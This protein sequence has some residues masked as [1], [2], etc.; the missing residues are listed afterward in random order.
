MTTFKLKI[1]LL[2]LSITGPTLRAACKAP[3]EIWVK[4]NEYIINSD[5]VL[6]SN[7]IYGKTFKITTSDVTIDCAGALLNGKSE[8]QTNR[9]GFVATGL[10]KV[11]I[12]NCHITNYTNAFQFLA[13]VGRSYIHPV[14]KKRV[15]NHSFNQDGNVLYNPNDEVPLFPPSDRIIIDNVRVFNNKSGG[16]LR[17]KNSI[18]QNSTFDKNG[19][20]LYIEADSFNNK[21]R[22]NTFSNSTMR[23]GLILD[24]AYDNHVY[25]NK[26]F[27]NLTHGIA[28]YK[29]CGERGDKWTRLSGATGNVIE[30]NEI[31][32]HQGMT[33]S[34]MS[35]RKKA[36]IAIGLR[37]GLMFQHPSRLDNYNAGCTDKRSHIFKWKRTSRY[38]YT[39]AIT[40]L[41]PIPQH[42]QDGR[43]AFY[44]GAHYDFAENNQLI[45]NIVYE[46]TIGIYVSSSHTEIDKS[47]FFKWHS[48]PRFNEVD[49]WFGNIV[50]DKINKS[51]TDLKIGETRSAHAKRPIPKIKVTT[52]AA[53]REI[54][55]PS[56]F[57]RGLTN[58]STKESLEILEQNFKGIH[59]KGG[60]VQ[61]VYF[62]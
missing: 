11:R 48:S 22:R 60:L 13:N 5:I 50:L 53:K 38:R 33:N 40:N 61:G 14:T 7:K 4:N 6:C 46:N 27:N 29:N 21:I 44:V 3:E 47:R 12:K 17:I 36:G 59:D 58:A 16:I 35:I 2:L 54:N 8:D 41:H 34:L 55:A 18:I 49:I 28:L 10:D 15:T 51:L 42:M 9:N 1:V 31:Y 25:Q 37:Q 62:K 32:G 19:L 43:N 24:G 20:G 26:V 23:E 57:Y 56:H 45:N 39:N 52:S 30:A